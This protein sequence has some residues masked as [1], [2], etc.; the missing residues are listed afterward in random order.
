M[1]V[2]CGGLLIDTDTLTTV[3]GVIC[4][5]GTTSVSS[6]VTACGGQQFDSADF[7]IVRKGV[8]PVVTFAKNGGEVIGN[9]IPV[10]AN[11]GL[12][13]DS[14]F[15][16]ID[17]DGS[18]VLNS[19]YILKISTV[20]SNATVA[21]VDSDGETVPVIEGTD[22]EYFV[23]GVITVYVTAEGY[24]PYEES[25]TL[26]KNSSITVTLHQYAKLTVNVTEPAE[27]ASIEVEDKTTGAAIEADEGTTNVFTVVDTFSYQVSVSADNYETS[28]Q[29]AVIDGNTTISVAL[30]PVG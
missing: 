19:G 16:E 15:F 18:L 10:K 20:P 9:V 27:G 13:V 3:N 14:R 21:V 2:Q 17:N 23:S 4:E 29:T 22:N 25:Y 6:V 11:C 7:K 28:T 1:A 30:T 8:V 24:N 5:S 26:T 12:A